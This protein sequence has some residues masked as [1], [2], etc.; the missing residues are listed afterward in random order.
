MATLSI[1]HIRFLC[2]CFFFG[3]EALV[4]YNI[5]KTGSPLLTTIP[6]P[7]EALLVISS[8][9]VCSVCTEVVVGCLD[10]ALAQKAK[11]K[12]A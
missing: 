10:T 1:L 7:W 2:T 11:P 12:T 6:P 8:I 3:I 9:A 4:H 5:G